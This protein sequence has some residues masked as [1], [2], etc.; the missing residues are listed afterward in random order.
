MDWIDFVIYL[1]IIFA[2]IVVAAAS[3]LLI[4]NFCNRASFHVKLPCMSVYVCVLRFFPF[5][6]SCAV[7]FLHDDDKRQKVIV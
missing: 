7:R 6:R 4:W 2:V 3:V 5:F 1:F